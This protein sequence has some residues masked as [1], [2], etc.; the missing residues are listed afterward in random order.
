ARVAAG[1]LSGPT[2]RLQNTSAVTRH[3]N[4]AVA[5]VTTCRRLRGTI[6]RSSCTRTACS[7]SGVHSGTTWLLTD[8]SRSV[9]LAIGERLQDGLRGRT[10]APLR[11]GER[12]SGEG[13]D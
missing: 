7:R 1:P 11:R 13:G 8:A 5:V 6:A 4:A 2:P 3:S 9:G 12:A 10:E